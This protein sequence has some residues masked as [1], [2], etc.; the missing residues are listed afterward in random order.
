MHNLKENEKKKKKKELLFSYLMVDPGHS[1][2][3][4]EVM[5][6]SHRIWWLG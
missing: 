6:D 1:H 5:P 2:Y 4:S 3:A